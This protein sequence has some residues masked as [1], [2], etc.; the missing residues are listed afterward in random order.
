MYPTLS[1]PK[2]DSTQHV[3]GDDS[4]EED[5]PAHILRDT[6]NP[7]IYIREV[8]KS[9]EDKAGK[10]KLNHRVYNSYHFCKY[11]H[12]KVSNFSQHILRAHKTEKEVQV[13]RAEMNDQQ[14]KILITACRHSSNHTGNMLTKTHQKGEIFLERRPVNE[15]SLEN[16]GP[17]PHCLA[18]VACHL[19]WKHQ[20][21]CIAGPNTLLG[22]GELVTRSQTLSHSIEPMASKQ[23]VKEVFEKMHVD[24]ISSIAK[25]DTLIVCLGNQWFVKNLGNRLKRG[26]YTG[27]I[28]RLAARLLKNLRGLGNH[29]NMWDFLVPDEFTN[30]VK[31]TL[32]TAK[33]NADLD[34]YVACDL[35]TPSNAKKLSHDIR[36]L[37]NIKI[38]M[39][40]EA[41]DRTAERDAEQVLKLIDVFW[42]ERVTKL[43][44]VVLER[45]RCN[46]KR[47]MP[48][49]SDIV[50]L[51][52]HL[53]DCI[54]NLQLHMMNQSNY[55]LVCETVLTKLLVYNRRRTGDM[56]SA[57]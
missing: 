24:E 17:C 41:K 9:K 39:A 26:K 45:R 18:W 13:I 55:Q 36:R 2:P 8:L 31:A 29:H 50:T 21:S 15:F 3:E 40:I 38:G 4:D 22:V 16:Y 52:Q 42:A 49:G 37:L 5:E 48:K 34:E 20:K 10:K 56:E 1:K 27:Q 47:L 51:S 7:R 44:T 23:L 28:M 25:K 12:R 19:L 54:T 57:R 14:R 46:M 32:M 33:P 11:C 43:A 35:E 30:L 6:T 53:K